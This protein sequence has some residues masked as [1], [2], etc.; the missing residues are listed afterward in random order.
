MGV[1]GIWNL[2][3]VCT[4]KILVTTI[5][6]W[7]SFNAA[8][9][10]NDQQPIEFQVSA[11]PSYRSYGMKPFTFDRLYKRT[12]APTS[13]GRVFQGIGL[14]LGLSA[15]YQQLGVTYA[16]NFLYDVIYMSFRPTFRS[17]RKFTV[18]HQ[19]FLFFQRKWRYS[20]GYFI[21]YDNT[22]Y[23]YQWD[24]QTHIQNMEFDGICLAI[25]APV[26]SWLNVEAKVMYVRSGYPNNPWEEAMLYGLRVYHTFDLKRKEK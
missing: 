24:G 16:P 25:A 3:S 22:S 10:A 18:D 8:S 14:T 20:A 11:G 2:R 13:V 12:V 1:I 4:M 9:Q 23:P 17:H 19:F 21:C 15:S 6:I 5:A 7:V 26:R